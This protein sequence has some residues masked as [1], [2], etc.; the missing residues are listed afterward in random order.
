MTMNGKTATFNRNDE[1]ARCGGHDPVLRTVKLPADSGTFP[2]GLLLT[3]LLTGVLVALQVLAAEVLG[4]GDGAAT[5]FAGTL[6]AAPLAPGSVSVTDGV[7]TFTDDG[8]GRLTGDAGGSG[9][10]NYRTG[11][12]AVTFNAAVGNGT[13]VTADAT[14]SCDAVLDE[15]VDT[16]A[17]QAGVAIVHGSVRRDVLKVGV[18]APVAPAAATLALLEERG[19]YPM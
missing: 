9:T 5:A 7:E 13:D 19:I 2:V 15:Q 8:S 16:A 4:A 3:R 10:V 14:T 17:M 11:D 12:I 1:R 18:N 6:S